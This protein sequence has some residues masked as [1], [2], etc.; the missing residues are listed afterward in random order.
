M[1]ALTTLE[2]LAT[3]TL[4]AAVAS[5]AASWTHKPVRPANSLQ[6]LLAGLFSRKF[7][8]KRLERYRTLELG[9]GNFERKSL[10]YRPIMIANLLKT[11]EMLCHEANLQKVN[12]ESHL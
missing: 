4:E 6:F 9:H 12:L 2:H 11:R 1:A 7:G 10:E 3:T 8:Q 5:G